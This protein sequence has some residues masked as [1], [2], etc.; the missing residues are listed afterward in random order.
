[1]IWWLDDGSLQNGW[2]KG[3]ICC[4]GFSKKSQLILVKYLQKVWGVKSYI[5]PKK[6]D[7]FDPQTH[8]FISTRQGFR[9]KMGTTNLIKFLKIF[10]SLIPCESM[11]YKVCL[12]YKRSELQQ[13]WISDLIEALPQYEKLIVD[14][15]KEKYNFNYFR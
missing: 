10:I 8:K 12:R 15:Y 4:E 14:H 3:V 11:V 5:V 7:Y 6:I 13:R 1:M 2:R 9:I